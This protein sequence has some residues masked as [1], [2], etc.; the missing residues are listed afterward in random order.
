MKIAASL[1]AMSLTAGVALAAP[2]PVE[3]IALTS[4]S[5]S[6]RVAQLERILKAKQQSEFEMQKR[7]D[8]L[9]QDVLDLRGLTEQ[10]GYQI[11]QMLQR[12]RQ[13]YDELANLSN[14]ASASAPANV[15]E[16]GSNSAPSS[17]SLSETASYEKAL[18][19]V[20]KDRQYAAAIPAFR[21]FISQYPD[22]P[23]AANANYWLGQLLY[24]KG[25]L[26]GAQKAFMRVVENYRDSTK[27]ADS[28]V[29]LGMIAQKQGQKKQA[30]QYYQNVMQEYADSAAA[31]IAQQK[32]AEL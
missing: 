18:N 14:S 21:Q 29:K 15:A 20:L 10:Q 28:L 1:A 9:Q 13:L 5:L 8:A 3:D 27:R 32:L 16:T 22:S 6:S 17:L 26:T 24:N 4:N 25:D 11:S 7:L 30:R 2:A 31:R 23:Y 12:Q 19:L